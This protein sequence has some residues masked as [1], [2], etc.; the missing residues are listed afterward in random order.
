MVEVLL[1]TTETAVDAARQ[2]VELFERFGDSAQS[3]FSS[4]SPTHRAGLWGVAKGSAF[5][6]R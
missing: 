5:G 4:V 1:T 2:S 3:S 6:R